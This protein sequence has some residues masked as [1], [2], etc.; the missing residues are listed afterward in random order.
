MDRS[1]IERRGGE[2]EVTMNSR[3][4]GFAPRRVVISY[5]LKTRVVNRIREW[6]SQFWL[7][8]MS[9]IVLAYVAGVGLK[10]RITGKKLDHGLK[11]TDL[12]G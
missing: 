3:N 10:A 2:S 12:D 7:M 1:A 8:V 11:T 6:E 9:G 5:P 4:R